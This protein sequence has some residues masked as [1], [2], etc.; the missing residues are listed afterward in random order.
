MERIVAHL[1]IKGG[2]DGTVGRNV[3]IGGQETESS[4]VWRRIGEVVYTLVEACI[5]GSFDEGAGQIKR[6]QDFESPR[7][8]Q[9]NAKSKMW[10]DSAIM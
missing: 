10:D 1:E 2:K 5:S 3:V 7:V 9:E 8:A 4:N 6:V